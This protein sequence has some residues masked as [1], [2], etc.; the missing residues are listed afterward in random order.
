MYRA[1]LYPRQNG[2]VPKNQCALPTNR[3]ANNP[4]NH[5]TKFSVIWDTL[6]ILIFM[7]SGRPMFSVKVP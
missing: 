7:G 1:A 6:I 5:I 2:W 3:K 4:Y